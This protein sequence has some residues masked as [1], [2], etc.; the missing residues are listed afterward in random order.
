M[1]PL[2]ST[3]LVVLLALICIALFVAVILGRPTRLY[4]R[5]ALATRAV[6][7]LLLN[8][9]VVALVGALVND[10]YLF[11]ITWSDL[12]GR[13]AGPPHVLVV[14]DQRGG[15]NVQLP[16]ALASITPGPPAPLPSPGSR[17]QSY[18]V[19]GTASHLTATV[20]VWLP[21]GYDPASTHT[22]PVIISMAGYPGSAGSNLRAFSIRTEYDRLVRQQHLI[23]PPIIV[24]PQVNVPN[25]LDTEC[26]DV[27]GTGPL[28]ETWL[29]SDLPQWVTTHFRVRTDRASWALQGYSYG[30]W[31]AA[32]LSM[33]HPAVFG[34]AMVLMGYFRPEFNRGA[35]LLTSAQAQAY[36]L[37]TMATHHPP[38]VSMWVMASK[39][40]PYAYPATARFL[41]AVRSPMAVTASIL[42]AGGHNVSTIEPVLPDMLRWLA[43]TAKGFRPA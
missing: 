21:Q 19:T 38:P 3:R 12:L 36:N 41:K 14:G 31:C 23:A 1:L 40:D 7:V 32:L 35:M 25:D 11:Y 5:A 15:T 26:V 28:T 34:A 30:G 22:Y 37:T 27:P 16:S 42:P 24:M 33:R 10:S 4:Q 6:S 39:A 18:T 43:A 29:A 2:L 20:D 9:L 17:L 8:L 13:D